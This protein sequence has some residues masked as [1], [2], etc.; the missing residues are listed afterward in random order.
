V[1]IK[2]FKLFIRLLVGKCWLNKLTVN[3][4]ECLKVVIL[5]LVGIEQPG[6]GELEGGGVALHQLR[7][8]VE[9]RIVAALT[10]AQRTVRHVEKVKAREPERVRGDGADDPSH[11]VNVCAEETAALGAVS[12]TIHMYWCAVSHNTS[13]TF[14]PVMPSP[15][16]KVVSV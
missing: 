7:R 12:L 14:C 3:T 10:R 1:N 16:K 11:R 6:E 15:N 5:R 13:G 2:G 8:D 4:N 9:V